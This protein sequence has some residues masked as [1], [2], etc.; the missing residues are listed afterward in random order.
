MGQKIVSVPTIGG[1]N[2]LM[3]PPPIP[4]NGVPSGSDYEIGQLGYNKAV[5]PPYPLYYYAGGN[6]WDNLS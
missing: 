4:F 2:A 1:P 5:S 6:T 3:G